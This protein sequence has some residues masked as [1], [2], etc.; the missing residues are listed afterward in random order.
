[1]TETFEKKHD[2]Y[3]DEKKFPRKFTQFYG[4]MFLPSLVG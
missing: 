3:S 1:M 4:G 2:Y